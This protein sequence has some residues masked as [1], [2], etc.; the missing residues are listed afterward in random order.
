MSDPVVILS[1]YC[2]PSS[3]G[4][5]GY[6]CGRLA[7]YVDGVAE[8]TLRKPPPLDRAMSVQPGP[9]GV[10]LV[11]DET[12][13]AEARPGSLELDLPPSPGLSAAVDAS[14]GYAGLEQHAFPECFVCGPARNIGDGLRI[15]AGPVNGSDM[16]AS[17]WTPQG[18]LGDADGVVRDEYAWAALDCPGAW[19]WLS[20]LAN[21]LVLGRLTA[22]IEA[23]ILTGRPHVVAGWRLGSDGR[24]HY[25][26][27][28]VWTADGTLCAMAKATWIEVDEASFKASVGE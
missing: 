24:K 6:T 23:P 15:F 12:V 21:P 14:G 27:T 18:W 1:R 16:V 25:S 17:A 4:N 20:G 9:D 13:I 28:A 22:R 5:G 19:A 8:V 3:S 7:A 11:A 2:G 26:G 10:A